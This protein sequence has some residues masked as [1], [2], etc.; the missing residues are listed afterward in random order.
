MREM[1]YIFEPGAIIIALIA[2]CFLLISID[3][4]RQIP[5]CFQCGAIKVR[6]SRPNGFLDFAGN[7]IMIR[8]YRCSGCRARF[9][10][11]RLFGRKTQHSPS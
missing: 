5:Q 6:P 9:H 4:G 8:A 10:A 2:V 7:L 3:R 1:F 11:M